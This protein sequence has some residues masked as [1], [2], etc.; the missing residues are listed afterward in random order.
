VAAG[1]DSLVVRVARGPV[2]VLGPPLEG[3]SPIK[4]ESRSPMVAFVAAI[5]Q[6]FVDL[7]SFYGRSSRSFEAGNR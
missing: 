1:Q 5:E 4:R 7:C 6:I 2:S 3:L